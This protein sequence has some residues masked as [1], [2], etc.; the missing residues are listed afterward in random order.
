MKLLVIVLN[1]TELIN[2]LLSVLVEAGISAATIIDSE[3]MGHHLAYNI[4]IFAGIKQFVGESGKHNKTILALVDEDNP[5][6]EINA[7]L[8][9][10]G[11]DFGEG[12]SGIMFTV[13]VSSKV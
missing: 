13:P 9:E 2:E 6:D 1:N 5:A 8:K 4:P 3:G 12:G 10:V 11:I 7:L